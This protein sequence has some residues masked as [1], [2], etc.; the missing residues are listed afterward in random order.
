ME[1]PF[2]LILSP[3]F[4]LGFAGVCLIIYGIWLYVSA[5]K[6]IK[7]LRERLL[8]V[9][10]NAQTITPQQ[11]FELKYIKDGD[12][13]GIYILKNN[14]N[15]KYYVGQAKK[16]FFRINQHFTGQGNSDI[17][18]DY[19]NGDNFTIKIIRLIDSGYSDIDKLER[20][21]IDLYDAYYT[22]YNK[23]KGNK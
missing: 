18:R 2:S 9:S 6:R 5:T 7:L 15:G 12:D 17:Y 21:Y 20:D 1:G 3:F 4:L 8:Q 11:F 22:G 13:V 16:T 23:T 19:V 14:T 10:I